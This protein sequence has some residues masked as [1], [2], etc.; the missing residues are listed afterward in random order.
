MFLLIIGIVLILLG[1]VV[2]RELGPEPLVRLAAAL[3]VLGGIVCAIVGIVDIAD[4]H[5]NDATLVAEDVQIGS[6]SFAVPGVTVVEVDTY[7]KGTIER[8]TY[9]K[10]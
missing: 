1:A 6:Y 2:Y 9:G 3:L 10:G 4:V 5:T 7:G 8:D